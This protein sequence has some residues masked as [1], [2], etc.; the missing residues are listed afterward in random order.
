MTNTAARGHDVSGFLST[1]GK[2]ERVEPSCSASEIRREVAMVAMRDGTR[3]ATELFFPP[4]LPANAIARRTPYGRLKGEDCMLEMARRGYVVISQDVRGTGDSEPSHW[5]F[6]IY[7]WEDSHDFVDWVTRQEWFAGFLGSFGASYN[8]GT[9]LCMAGHSAM[10]AVA[11]EVAGLGVAPSHGVRFH[12]LINS[13]SKSVGKGKGKTPIHHGEMER[14]MLEETL[15]TGYFRDPIAA[16]MPAA[17]LARYPHL[18]DMTGAE[19]RAWLWRHYNTLAPAERADLISVATESEIVTFT[20]TTKLNPVFGHLVDP[21]ALM[22]PRTSTEELCAAIH[23]P[24]L[25]ITGW[26]DWCLGDTL[27]SWKQLQL[28]GNDAVRRDSRL[29]VTP[30]AHNAPGYREG[31]ADHPE[32][33][34]TFRAEESPQVLLHYYEALQAGRL[35]E[36]QPVTYYLMGANEWR[37][38]TSW[39]PAE[40]RPVSLHLGSGGALS[41][42]PPQSDSPPD[43]Y[44]YDPADPPPTLGGSILSYV[45]TP[46]SVDI[47]TLH[48]RDDVLVYTTPPLDAD[49]DV[50]GPLRLVLYA[51]SSALDT[52][53]YGR[54]SD[55]FPDGRAIA[56]QSGVLRARYRNAGDEPEVLEPGRAYRFEIDMWATAN[57]FRAGH[58]LRLDICSADFPKFERNDNRAGNPGDPVTAIQKIFHDT[59]RP[60]HLVLS[61]LSS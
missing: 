21:D 56:L 3:L 53:F 32:L 1:L 24:A 38:A 45:V 2:V 50:V 18:H 23:A 61:V 16:E 42:T 40:A 7:E 28:H 35:E 9:Q 49:L 48:V 37:T 47:Q 57:R 60:S 25:F 31:E 36:I 51:S 54:L 14:L 30:A 4:R 59:G 58:S 41:W 55:V 11:P 43:G 27:E 33:R 15:A 46:G 17:V 10:S 34:R 26:Y 19:G 44:V 12:M 8:G 13:Y 6:D 52:D 5:D 20:S 39:P 22:L 29:L